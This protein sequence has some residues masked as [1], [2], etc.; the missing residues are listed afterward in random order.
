[1]GAKG[2]ASGQGGTGGGEGS[3]QRTSALSNYFRALRHRNFRLFWFGQLVSL[4][5]T[6]MQSSAILWLVHRLTREPIWLGAAGMATFL[7]VLLFSLFAGVIVDRVPKRR[8]II[9]T[10]AVSLCLALALGTLTFTGA[11]TVHHILV[12][13]FLLG[14]VNAFDMPARQSF[15]IEMVGA[16]D[17]LNAVALNSSVFNVARV[18]GPSIAGIL[19]A[20]AGEAPCFFLNSLSFVPIIVG[21]ASMRLPERPRRPRR[22][23]LQEV[24]EGLLFT[25]ATP[26]I[27]SILQA[28]AIS[29]VFGITF[30]ILLPV[31]ADDVLGKGPRAYGL[32]L[33]AFGAGAV[34][35]AL[36]L[37]GRTSTKGS[38]RL[39]ALGMATLG[40]SLVAFS[41]SRSFAL[42]EI[43]LFIVGGAMV[44]QL[45]TTNTLLQRLAPDEMRGRILSVYTF[46]LVG[47]TP[48][49]SVLQG[50]VAQRLGA[51]WSVRIGA[52]ICILGAVWFVTRIPRWRAALLLQP[53]QDSA[54]AARPGP[55]PGR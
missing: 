36:R 2:E 38:A 44:T 46:V 32:L 21:L 31:F 53:L 48:V 11:V 3:G 39:V 15:V 49:G 27:R 33:G 54:G 1:M 29:S 37:A 8:L 19:I 13:A 52:L 25:I 14:T 20:G 12:V 51:P 47:L 4:I 40:L 45:A 5:G 28:V 6:W 34:V 22:P 55:Y 7:P 10:Q 9:A 41:Y 16:E 17:V 42:S 23:I 18:I 26:R 50:A 35:G 30:T 43:L 24:R